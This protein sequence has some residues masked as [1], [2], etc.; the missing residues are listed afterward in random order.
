[1]GL[2]LCVLERV[3]FFMESAKLLRS[4][5]VWIEDYFISSVLPQCARFGWRFLPLKLSEL[6]GGLYMSS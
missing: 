3:G 6:L 5:R 4:L 2:E 1:M